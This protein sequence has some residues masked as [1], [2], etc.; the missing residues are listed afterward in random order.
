M[1]DRFVLPREL[2]NLGSDR[3]FVVVVVA[4]FTRGFVAAVVSGRDDDQKQNCLVTFVVF[5]GCIVVFQQFGATAI[6]DA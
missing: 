2:R 3:V 5:L 4:L 6:D 1:A